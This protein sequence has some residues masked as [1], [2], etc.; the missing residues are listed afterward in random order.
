MYI[1]SHSALPTFQHLQCFAL[2]LCFTLSADIVNLHLYYVLVGDR[3]RLLKSFLNL[4]NSYA[5]IRATGQ[6]DSFPV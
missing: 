5:Q 3:D 6:F 2:L 1:T 4:P